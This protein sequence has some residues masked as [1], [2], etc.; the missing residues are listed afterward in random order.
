MK[1]YINHK[2]YYEEY[3]NLMHL[4]FEKNELIRELKKLNFAEI[5]FFDHAVLD[6]GNSKFRFNLSC[7]K[8]SN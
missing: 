7:K 2:K 3:K 6:Y 4:F 8:L 5:Q 1:K